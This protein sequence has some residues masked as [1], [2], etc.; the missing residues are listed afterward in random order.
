M[1]LA[2]RKTQ[3]NMCVCVRDGKANGSALRERVPV[4]V[5]SQTSITYTRDIK[6]TLLHPRPSRHSNKVLT[7]EGEHNAK[8]APAVDKCRGPAYY[9]FKTRYPASQHLQIINNIRGGT[10]GG[11]GGYGKAI[12]VELE[13]VFTT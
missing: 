3:V 10:W 11:G 8:K 6:G 5:C 9:R 13:G 7:V 1:L 2:G 12:T 4:R